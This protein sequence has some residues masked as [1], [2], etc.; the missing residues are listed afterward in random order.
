MGL[1][2]SNDRISKGCVFSVPLL[3]GK[4][5]TFYYRT[6][7]LNRNKLNPTLLRTKKISDLVRAKVTSKIFLKN[8]KKNEKYRYQKTLKK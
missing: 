6:Y 7:I 8:I 3:G 1:F 2:H 5:N 4:K